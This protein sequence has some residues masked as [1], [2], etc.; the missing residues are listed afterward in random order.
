MRVPCY[1]SAYKKTLDA[2]AV[3]RAW[4]RNTESVKRSRGAG[5]LLLSAAA[6]LHLR[7]KPPT[8]AR[9]KQVPATL[10]L[11][12]AGER[13]RGVGAPIT[14]ITPSTQ[15]L[16]RGRGVGAPTAPITPSLSILLRIHTGHCG[17]G[18]AV[19][20]LSTTWYPPWL[21]RRRGVGVPIT[22]ITPSLPLWG[23]TQATAVTCS[24]G[25][26][27]QRCPGARAEPVAASLP[28]YCTSWKPSG[29]RIFCRQARTSKRS[30]LRATASCK[31]SANNIKTSTSLRGGKVPHHSTVDEGKRDTAIFRFSIK[32]KNFGLIWV[33]FGAPDPLL[34]YSETQNLLTGCKPRPR[35]RTWHGI[36]EDL[37]YSLSG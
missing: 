6:W 12:R 33:D 29:H 17:H 24:P 9:L 5:P 14:P 18:R 21:V 1:A 37:R 35:P 8:Q 36:Q 20:S 7:C 3:F 34:F 16:L 11:A 27:D 4:R 15:W 26:H 30:A 2:A 23:S 28:S 10:A 31:A 19:Q 25:R 13:V 22:P 32:S